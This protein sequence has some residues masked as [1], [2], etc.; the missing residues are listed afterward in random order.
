MY[1]TLGKVDV[2]K[3]GNRGLHGMPEQFEESP[4]SIEQ[5]AG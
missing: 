1:A 3:T 4:N 5:D 2:R